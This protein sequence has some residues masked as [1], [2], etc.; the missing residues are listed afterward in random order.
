[1]SLTKAIQFRLLMTQLTDEECTQFFSTVKDKIVTVLFQHFAE[2]N[3]SDEVNH[4]NNSLSDIIQSRAEKPKLLSTRNIKLH[5]FPGAIIGHTASFLMQSEY[6]RFTTTNR[7]IYLG[8][9]LPSNQL[10]ALDLEFENTGKY[11]SMDLSSFPSV[12]TLR[13]A[14]SKIIASQHRWSFDSPNFNQIREL[15]LNTGNKP[16]RDWAE[17]FFNQ[18][19]VNCDT[20]TS[21]EYRQSWSHDHV[22]MQKKE[23]L[24]LLARFP[25]L[26]TLKLP[27]GL[28][29]PEDVTPKDIADTCPKLFGLTL[30]YIRGNPDRITVA[31]VKLFASQLKYLSIFVCKNMGVM[32]FS[33]VCFGKLEELRIDRPDRMV[34][35]TILKSAV[36]LKKLYLRWTFVARMGNDREAIQNDIANLMV[37]C[38]S[39][40]FMCFWVGCRDDFCSVLDGIA[41]GLVEIKRNNQ[42]KQQLKIC[43]GVN[44]TIFFGE[45]DLI[46]GVSRIVD[47]L[48]ASTVKDFMFIVRVYNCQND[49]LDDIFK[50]LCDLQRNVFR[51]DFK[52]IS[53]TKIETFIITN[54]NCKINGYRSSVCGERRMV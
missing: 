41:S 8:C 34:F 43:F 5:Q 28:S 14:P 19:I 52:I 37:K 30:S 22:N 24:S 20:V 33:D 7:S 32:D 38:T 6:V 18:N 23:F 13:V 51:W 17:S 36:N 25:N 39:L 47:A 4:F 29:I 49:E 53:G 54:D 50:N 3:Q 27:S 46:L 42:P 15:S 40:H 48:K 35:P 2:S 10:Q 16:P 21:L 11:A 12:K 44:N 9:N 26:A 45:N 1:M 31:L